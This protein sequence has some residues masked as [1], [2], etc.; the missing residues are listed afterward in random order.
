[1][2]ANTIRP[3]PAEIAGIR[4]PDTS[5]AIAATELVREVSSPA[6]FNHVVRTYIFGEQVGRNMGMRYD[7]ELVYIA[8]LMH[9]LGLTAPFIGTARFE[10]DGADAAARFLMEHGVAADKIDRVWDAI[11]LHSSNGIADHKQPEVALVHFGAAVDVAGAMLDQ[12]P[13]EVFHQTLDAYPRLGFKKAFLQAIVD[14][15]RKKPETGY[16]NFMEGIGKRYLTDFH[17]PDVCEM[18]L[19]SPYNE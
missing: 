1:M 6:L 12:I 8:A 19:G 11:A 7:S 18:I 16:L 2:I 4:I 17:P 10:V 5:L 15:L 3:M 9:D 13:E 14:V